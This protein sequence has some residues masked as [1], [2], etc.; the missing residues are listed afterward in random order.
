MLRLR[1][2]LGREAREVVTNLSGNL[3]VQLGSATE[4]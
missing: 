3:V 2:P 4:G 1:S